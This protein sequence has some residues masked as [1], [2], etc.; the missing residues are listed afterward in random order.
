MGEATLSDAES[1]AAKSAFVSAGRAV[2]FRHR[3]GLRRLCCGF[4]RRLLGF[5]IVVRTPI[6]KAEDDQNHQHDGCDII[7][8]H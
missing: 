8:I 5:L 4:G 3:R 7:L 6:R 2:L 1:A